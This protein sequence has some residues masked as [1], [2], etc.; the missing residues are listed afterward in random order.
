MDLE[1]LGIFQ[2][3]FQEHG[4]RNIELFQESSLWIDVG[5]RQEISSPWKDCALWLKVNNVSGP[6]FWSGS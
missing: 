4:C 3:D 2:S 5:P 1:V 6:R